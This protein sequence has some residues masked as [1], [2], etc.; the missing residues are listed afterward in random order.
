MKTP[1][2]DPVLSL[3]RS[4]SNPTMAHN[5][6]RRVKEAVTVADRIDIMSK[7]FATDREGEQSRN[8]QA[9]ARSWLRT[10]GLLCEQTGS[11]HG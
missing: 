2:N 11:K 3:V 5:Y 8:A 10:H 7:V 6:V 4:G 9:C 1:D